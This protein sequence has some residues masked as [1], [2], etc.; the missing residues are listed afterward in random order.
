M[1]NNLLILISFLCSFYFTANSQSE[2]L[3]Y[4]PDADASARIRIVPSITDDGFAVFALDSSVIYR[5]TNCGNILWSK[6][7]S[8]ALTSYNYADVAS[9][10]DGSFVLL[11]RTPFGNYHAFQLTRLSASGT[12]L[13]S[14][15]YQLN[16]YDMF[17]YTISQDAAGNLIMYGNIS[18]QNVGPNYNLLTKLDAN[19]NVIWSK[20]YNRGMIWGGCLNTSD[21]GYLM[22]T[23]STFIKADVN[24]NPQWISQFGVSAYNYYAPVEVSDGYIFNGSTSNYLYFYK[25]DKTGNMLWNGIKTLNISTAPN[26]IHSKPNGN[27]ATVVNKNFGGKNHPGILEFDGNLN[28]VSQNFINSSQAG[29]EF[30]AGDVCFTQSGLPAVAGKVLKTDSLTSSHIYF[31][32]LNAQYQT[33][34]DTSIAINFGSDTIFKFP[35]SIAATNFS[36]NV[37]AQTETSANAANNTEFVCSNFPALQLQLNDD[38]VICNNASVVLQNTSATIFENYLWSTGETTPTITVSDTG[39]YFLRAIGNCGQDTLVDSVYV[40]AVN[41]SQPILLKDTT[42]CENLSVLLNATT[43][44]ATYLWQDG[45]TASTFLATQQ[46]T[47]FVE[48]KIQSCVKRITT[49]VDE[50]EILIMPNVFTPNDDSFNNTF[51]PIKMLGIKSANLFIY[52]RWGQELYSSH[53]I[54]NKGWN[55]THLN[56]K[57][58]DGVYFWIVDYENYKNEKK[59]QHGNV[60]L[61]GN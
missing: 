54:K 38:A 39:I 30:F 28:I 21:G 44:N 52:N 56:K 19:G 20:G 43:N 41:I 24:G 31:G 18:Y 50:C 14:K 6:K 46:G 55:G 4:I 47:Y 45:S 57:S 17:P 15:T 35:A 12:I 11:L 22:R 49:T 9:L 34:C 5:I 16:N 25:M 7:L 26:L 33:S 27:F 29:F 59:S 51:V 2:Y 58:S 13:W 61:I 23:S 3:K 10:N 53:D 37:S 1:K 36:L 60:H 8:V 40:A 42:I 32:K 48:I